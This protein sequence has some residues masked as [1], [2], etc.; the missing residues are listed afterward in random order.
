MDRFSRGLRD[1]YSPKYILLNLALLPVYFVVFFALIAYQN[2]GIPSS[3]FPFY[4]I[5]G[6][7]LTS[8]MLATIAIYSIRN[9]TNNKARLSASTWGTAAAVVGGVI[10]GCGCGAPL[11]LNVVAIGV[12]AGEA[13]ALNNFLTNYQEPIFLTLIIVNIG[14]IVYYLNKLS[15]PTCKVPMLGKPH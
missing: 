13:I 7:V 5:A 2:D 14:M 10:G 9:T 8:S 12:S 1:I 6:L 15:T 4:W 11:V 3:V